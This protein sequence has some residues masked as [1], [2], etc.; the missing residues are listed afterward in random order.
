MEDR[1]KYRMLIK[2]EHCK[3]PFDPFEHTME[4]NYEVA[5]DHVYIITDYRCPHCYGVTRGTQKG[6]VADWDYEEF[7]AV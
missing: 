4:T 3:E 1:I 7:E 2:C 6:V 5:D